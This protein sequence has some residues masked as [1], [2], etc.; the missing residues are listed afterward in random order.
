M[1]RFARL[2][3]SA[4]SLSLV[5]SVSAPYQA[6]A[7]FVS[8]RVA[9]VGA[10]GSIG[11]SAAAAGSLGTPNAVLPAANLQGSGFVPSLAPSLVTPAI[12]APSAIATL[13]PA[14]AATEPYGEEVSLPHAVRK[15]PVVPAAA[16]P[17]KAAAPVPAISALR[18][19]GAALTAA[20][21]SGSV[22]APRVALDGLF[23]GSAARPETLAVSARSAASD[24]PRLEPSES[25]EPAKG[26][27]WVGFRGPED[28]PR[29]TLKRT[30]AVGVL[31]AVAPL[32]FT[33][34]T[35]SVAQL[36]GYHLHPNYTSPV[37]AAV[38]GLVQALAIWA[39]AAIMAPVSEEAIFRGGLQGGILARISAKLKLGSFVVPA[40]ITAVAFTALHETS[41]PVLFGTRLA[42]A[43]LLSW[44]YK[45]EGI[46]ASM[47]SHGIFNGLLAIT[48]VFTAMGAPLLSLAVAP[49]VIAAVLKA[50]AYL[51][52][53]K[54]EIASGAV[55]PVRL[56]AAVSVALAAL[57]AAGY[58]LIM[59]NIV[60]PVGAVA[61][62]I[63][64]VRRVRADKKK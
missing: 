1:N 31:G 62:L 50:R 22:D 60:W 24:S 6:A 28:A 41:D 63:N 25:R 43:L 47:A 12:T 33:M 10:S 56:S 11:A 27:R 26:P 3:A 19:G 15:G 52:A 61:L 42:Q 57:L 44:V 2:V 29:S 37:G 64:A 17:E 35:V 49:L 30:F 21:K 34:V 18:S 38:P 45:K 5:L 36:L 8:A 51:K 40:I 58:F 46:L 14:A 13:N 4:L 48:L 20:A 23:E 7:Q 16:T 9:P 59:P 54:P 53:Q 55:A 39:G 32:V